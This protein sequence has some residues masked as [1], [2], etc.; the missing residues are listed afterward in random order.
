MRVTL[1]DIAKATGLSV[2]TVSLVLNNKESRLSEETRKKVFETAQRLGYRSNQMAIDLQKGSSSTL[3][4]IVPDISND[5][6]STFSKGVEEICRKNNWTLILNNSDNL[7]SREIEYIDFLYRK[8]VDGIIL[9]SAP[10]DAE[11]ANQSLKSLANLKIP[12]VILDFTGTD[13]GNVVA[14]DH[15]VGGFQ[16]TEHLIKLGHKKIACLTGPLFLEGVK[17][18]LRGGSVAKF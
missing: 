11:L 8:N 16:A 7:I 10:D 18:K 6:Y 15:F 1:K 2:T 4:L 17:S 9:A 14:G 12:H 3:G 13:K 5:F